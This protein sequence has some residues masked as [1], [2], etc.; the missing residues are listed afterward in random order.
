MKSS[1]FFDALNYTP[2][3]SKK[4][5]VISLFSGC[6]GMDLGL[7][8]G[9]SV[10]GQDY[11]ENPFEVVHASDINPSA[12][13]SYNHN[14]TSAPALNVDI[15]EL[16]VE[17][18]P[19]ADIVIGGFP[20]QP[21]SHSGL[22]GGFDDVK[23][24]GALYQQ[25]KRVIDH[26]KPS[27]FIAENVDG[28]RTKK[29]LG[30]NGE[31]DST[32]LERVV[33]DFGK[34]GYDVSYRV[35]KAVD[36]GIPQTRV[37]VIIIGKRKD[38]K[39]E[40]LYP[41]S[42]H[43]ADLLPYRSSK[44]ALEDLWDLLDTGV[45]ENHTSKDYSK[46]VFRPGSKSQGNAQVPENRPAQTVRA[47]SHGNVYAHYKGDPNDMLAWRRLTARECARLQSFPDTFVFPVSQ[48]QAHKQI[49]NAVP[50]VLA[51]FIGRAC[52]KMLED[53]N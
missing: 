34:S 47:E 6:G 8:G 45:V 50:P 42:T 32:A 44:D 40:I 53:E 24:R 20:C 5:K 17:D 51:W 3:T 28:L 7:E 33:E 11:Q 43:G 22:R 19:E 18:L 36:Y 27:I 16:N 21:F 38:I 15:N 13:V 46:A 2:K 31:A 4:H 10:F 23:G 52:A 9:F 29:V 37:R 12:T 25:M 14:F 49:G 39:G 1:E 30:A 48:S 26:V 35:L 41:A